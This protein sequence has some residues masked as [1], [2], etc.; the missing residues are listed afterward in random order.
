MRDE[1]PR[2]DVALMPHLQALDGSALTWTQ[3]EE[4]RV[5][6]YAWKKAQQ[7]P[8]ARFEPRR[9]QGGHGYYL[10]RVD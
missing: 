7:P 6:Y 10:A 3:I 4:R 5:A 1:G 8:T 2:S 9:Y